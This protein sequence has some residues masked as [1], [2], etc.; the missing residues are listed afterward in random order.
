MQVPLSAQNTCRRLSG[1]PSLTVSLKLANSFH[2]VLVPPVPW[3]GT[4]L[5]A[6]LII[7]P[8][9]IDLGGSIAVGRARRFSRAVSLVLGPSTASGTIAAL[10]GRGVAGRL[11]TPHHAACLDSAT[12]QKGQTPAKEEPRG[13]DI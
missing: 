6:A 8:S 4:F 1:D 13:L 12:G 9:R 3:T 5:V 7:R 2:Y 10:H 11:P